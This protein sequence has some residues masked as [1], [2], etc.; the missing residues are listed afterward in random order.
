MD[1]Q[2]EGVTD[3]E[4][5]LLQ[6]LWEHGPSTIR[7][8]T[9]ILYP[10]G[11]DAHYATVQKLLDRLESKKHVQRDRST[12]AHTFA[13]AT[14]RDTLVGGQ[15]RAMAEKLCGGLMTPLLTHLVKAETLT[16]K[17]REELRAL[18]DEMDRKNST[19]KPPR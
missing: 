2:L 1:P 19:K 17:E 3:T 10:H 9:D 5:K 7:Q 16:A 15:L 12:H 8:L 14:D 13:A 11:N 18:I 4:L 6:A